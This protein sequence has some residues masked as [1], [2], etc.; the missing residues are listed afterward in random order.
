MLASTPLMPSIMLGTR[1]VQ[2]CLW[3]E[4][5]N[6]LLIINYIALTI[7]MLS[8]CVSTFGRVVLFLN[9]PRPI[10]IRKIVLDDSYVSSSRLY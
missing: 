2:K 1:R 8:G 10:I 4:C 7:V 6:K 5:I 3:N 9:H